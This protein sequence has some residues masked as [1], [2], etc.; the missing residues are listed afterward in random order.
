MP[1]AKIPVL[2]IEK[3]WLKKSG[4]SL[5][6]HDDGS[7]G[8]YETFAKLPWISGLGGAGTSTPADW[9]GQILP[10]ASSM[11]WL[12]VSWISGTTG[13]VSQG[14]IPIFSANIAP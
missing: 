10:A 5:W 2:E 14:I 9:S 8:H 6:F 11:G 12:K 3:L 1:G 13:S 4:R 7:V